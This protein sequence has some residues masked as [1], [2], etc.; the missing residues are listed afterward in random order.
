M[1]LDLVF[2]FFLFHFLTA[3]ALNLQFKQ[4]RRS[5]Q[6]RRDQTASVSITRQQSKLNGVHELA[7]G[8]GTG[9]DNSLDLEYAISRV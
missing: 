5:P 4:S 1:K 7:E 2:W 6:Q 3:S 9:G 8:T